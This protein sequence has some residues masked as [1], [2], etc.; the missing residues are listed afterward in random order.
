MLNI[1]VPFLNQKYSAQMLSAH[2][3]SS[4]R[5][6]QPLSATAPF[7]A[8]LYSIVLRIVLRIVPRIVLRIAHSPVDTL[9]QRLVEIRIMLSNNLSVSFRITAGLWSSFDFLSPF[10]PR[11]ITAIL[12]G[13]IHESPSGETDLVRHRFPCAHAHGGT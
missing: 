1:L 2:N 9:R 7:R 8:P 12:R 10:G 3:Q 11:L 4:Q 6:L 13:F 5:H